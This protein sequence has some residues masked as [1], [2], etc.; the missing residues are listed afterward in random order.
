MI[1]LVPRSMR[2]RLAVVLTPVLAAGAVLLALAGMPPQGSPLSFYGSGVDASGYYSLPGP[3]VSFAAILGANPRGFEYRV[4]KVELIPLPG[5]RMPQLVGAV[6]LTK[7]GVPLQ[8]PGFPPVSHVSG[9]PYPVQAMKDF[10]ARSGVIPYRQPV[11]LMYGI[12]GPRL[13]GYAV[14]GIRVTYEVRRRIYSTAIYNGALIFNRLAR[15]SAR[16]RRLVAHQ[17][18]VMGNRVVKALQS[19]PGAKAVLA[20][21]ISHRQG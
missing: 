10:V 20:W 3:P 8:A 13:G 12:R 1:R 15:E 7:G 21:E 11:V 2:G 4:L 16:T 5:F 9:K 14:A 19:L 6:F 18:Q 17:Y